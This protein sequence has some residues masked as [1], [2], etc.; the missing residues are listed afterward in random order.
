MRDVGAL[1][2]AQASLAHVFR[3]AAAAPIAAAGKAKAALRAARAAEAAAAAAAGAA[4]AEAT[5]GSA[6]PLADAPWAGPWAAEDGN[7]A[8]AAAADGVRRLLPRRASA[9]AVRTELRRIS[10]VIGV[11]APAGGGGGKGAGGGGSAAGSVAAAAEAADGMAIEPP[12]SPAMAGVFV[13]RPLRASGRLG[14]RV[15][16]DP[17]PAAV[18]CNP[19]LA[20]TCLVWPAWP[21]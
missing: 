12:S 17:Q 13:T 19:V 4:A 20:C 10:A 3:A 16:G 15:R 6:G 1:P 2:D 18:S 21:A 8:A 14:A 11:D 5:A 7:A 9:A